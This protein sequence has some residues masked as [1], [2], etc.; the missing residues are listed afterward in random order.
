MDI[1]IDSIISEKKVFLST[2]VV[3]LSA[4]DIQV[5]RSFFTVLSFKKTN[6]LIT[7]MI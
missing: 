5:S 6:P 7:D 4:D 3:N 2:Y 1:W